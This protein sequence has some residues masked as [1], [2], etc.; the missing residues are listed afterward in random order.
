MGGLWDGL[1][2][3]LDDA[4]V[5]IDNNGTERALR[6]LILGRNN[7][8]GSRSRRGTEVAALFYSSLESCKLAGVGPHTYLKGAASAALRG[9]PISLP[10][11]LA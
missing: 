9:L 11:E 5:D 10:H 4:N 6:G 3:S 1:R 2:V 8:F 7:H